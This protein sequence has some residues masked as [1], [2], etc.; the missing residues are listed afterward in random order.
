M[1]VLLSRPTNPNA[2]MLQEAMFVLV[3]LWMNVENA[4]GD[5]KRCKY[6][7]CTIF[8]T[9]MGSITRANEEYITFDCLVHRF[10]GS[11]EYVLARDSTGCLFDIHIENTSPFPN[12]IGSASTKA[13]AIRATDSE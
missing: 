10:Q 4:T 13:V 3:Q 6:A 1:V 9:P 2:E 7:N 8:S 5:G 11:C 12:A